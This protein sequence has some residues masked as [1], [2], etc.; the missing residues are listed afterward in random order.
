MN[1]YVINLSTNLRLIPKRAKSVSDGL[2]LTT[3]FRCT[4]GTVPQL[5]WNIF[6]RNCPQHAL[7]LTLAQAE[8]FITLP[9]LADL[10]SL[11]IRCLE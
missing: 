7:Q 9:A 6:G 8:C 1:D 11:Y 10:P 5:P 2:L 4:T 3:I